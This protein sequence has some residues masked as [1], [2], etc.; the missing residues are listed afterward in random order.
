MKVSKKF[1][2]IIG[3]IILAVVLGS[4]VRTYVQQAGEQEQLRTSL[5]AQQTLLRKLTT[6]EA[7]LENDWE[8]AESL[9][10]TSQAKFPGSVESIEYGEDLFEIA[11]DC[12]LQ[13]TELTPSMPA[14]KKVGAVT[15]SV[16]T[17]VVKVSGSMDNILD[18]VYAMR[19]GDGFELPWSAHVK[20]ISIATGEEM[21]ATITLDIYAYRR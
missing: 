9:L 12:N 18:F 14:D 2:L 6:D 5:A 7:N 11:G 10:N 15:Y 16:A 1:W 20:G 17:F 21:E 3:I 8:Q 13:V 19:T 4:L